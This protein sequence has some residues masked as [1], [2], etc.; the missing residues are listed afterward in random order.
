[1]RC[2]PTVETVNQIT[3]QTHTSCPRVHEQTYHSPHPSDN[4][5]VELLSQACI[6]SSQPHDP[7]LLTYPRPRGLGALA[8]RRPYSRKTQFCRGSFLGLDP[9]MAD[10]HFQTSRKPF[11]FPPPPFF[12][13]TLHAEGMLVPQHPRTA[14]TYGLALEEVELGSHVGR[15]RVIDCHGHCRLVPPRCKLPQH[16]LRTTMTISDQ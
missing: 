12:L 8:L 13:Q 3:E 9:R 6:A 14:T 5:A 7:Q 10:V 2:C 15:R 1:M 16:L 11:P 4:T